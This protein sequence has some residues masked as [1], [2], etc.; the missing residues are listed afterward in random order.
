METWWLVDQAS[1]WGAIG[2]GVGA[3]LGVGG[4]VVGY[5]LPQGRGH[6]VVLTGMVAIGVGAL[7]CAAAGVVAVADSQPYA[8]YFPLLLVGCVVYWVIVG[9]IPQIDMG[10]R[11]VLRED[12]SARGRYGQ[13]VG[14]L[15]AAHA[16]VGSIV[17]LWG[18]WRLLVGATFEEWFLGMLVGAGFLFS[19]VQLWLVK[20]MAIRGF[21]RARQ[22]QRLAAEELRRS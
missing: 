19:M 17:L 18:G 21:S 11:N 15:I 20:S 22:H 1:W 14:P 12:W 2:G 5:L 16:V 9:L 10:Y 6:R 4:A 13:W 3:L 8:V 7:L